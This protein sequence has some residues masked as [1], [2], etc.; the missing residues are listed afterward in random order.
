[1]QC[2]KHALDQAVDACG[3]CLRPSCSACL[4]P[5][6]GHAHS[7][8]CVACSLV[9][10]KVRPGKLPKAGRKEVKAARDLVRTAHRAGPPPVSSFLP[11]LDL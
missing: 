3:A 6:P 11:R 8:L 1:M 7:P 9:R 4:V 5:V 10:A 2:T